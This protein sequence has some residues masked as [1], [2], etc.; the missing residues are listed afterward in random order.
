MFQLLPAA[1]LSLHQILFL[2]SKPKQS[3]LDEPYA[4]VHYPEFPHRFYWVPKMRGGSSST[5]AAFS[6]DVVKT[7]LCE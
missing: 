3:F 6:C 7:V 4:V 1:Q 2:K 5:Y